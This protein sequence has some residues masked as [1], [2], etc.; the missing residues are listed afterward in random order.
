ML[1]E[2]VLHRQYK[3]DG[4]QLNNIKARTNVLMTEFIYLW[5]YEMKEI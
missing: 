4:G 3:D 2:S 5:R 1:S